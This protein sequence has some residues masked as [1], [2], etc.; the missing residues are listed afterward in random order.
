ME[1]ENYDCP[2]EDHLRCMQH[3]AGHFLV[4]YLL[5]VLPKRYRV[6][7]MEGLRQ[8]EFAGGKV[9]FLGFEFLSELDTATTLYKDFT[10][11]KL[12]DVAIKRKISFT[13]LKRFLCVILGGLVAEHLV[14]GY[15]EGH[16]SD[17]E[18]LDSVLKWVGFSENEADLQVR[19]AALNTVLILVRHHEARS[20][21]A[22]AMALGRSVGFCIDTIE[23]T[24]HGKDI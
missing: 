3:E 7:S 16:Y 21:L 12:S 11:G 20:R 10:K 8:E 24:L 18:K 15:S 9:E 14:F 17:V 6:P 1:G 4:G 23:S 5:G 22:E 19:W 2:C 13:V